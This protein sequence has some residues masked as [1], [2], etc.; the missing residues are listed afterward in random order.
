MNIIFAGT[1]H[2][3]AAHL[4]A[5]IASERSIVAVITQPDKPGKRGRHEVASP[6][7]EIALAAKL[8]ILQPKKLSLKDLEGYDYDLLIV[9]AFGQLLS[10]SIL[11][12]PK[13]GCINV[14]ASLLPRWRGAAPIQR[15]I[16]AGDKETGICIMQMDAGLDTGDILYRKKVAILKS[17]TSA[18]LSA[19]IEQTGIESL[20]ATL[21]Q[22]ETNAGDL[23]PQHNKGV[24]YAKKIAKREALI[25]WD[26]S[27]VKIERHIRA[28]NP[29]PISYSFLGSLRIKIWE[30]KAIPCQKHVVK[31]GTILKIEK[32][33][34]HVAALGD[35]VVIKR[36]QLPI[37]KGGI[38]KARDIINSRTDLFAP[39]SCFAD[40]P[41]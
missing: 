14:H 27:A 16:L 11:N 5:L 17:D 36:L 3:S 15:A 29:D 37:G 38:L 40:S 18:T 32:D 25:N 35:E 31:P 12:A 22:L 13:F 20:L 24:T 8:P 6:V 28:F 21:S 7:K 2:F 23:M 9:V 41:K 26:N 10:N 4:E 34:I 33:G 30:A 1:P 19:R 39:G